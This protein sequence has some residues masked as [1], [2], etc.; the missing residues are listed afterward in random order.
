MNARLNITPTGMTAS[1]GNV[2]T[3]GVIGGV[4]V[5]NNGTDAP[6]YWAG[7][8]TMATITA[9]PAGYTCASLRPFKNYRL[10]STFPRA[11]RTIRIW[12]CGAASRAWI[13]SDE[14]GCDRQDEER[15]RLASNGRRSIASRR[16]TATW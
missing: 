15:R 14:L 9:W 7:T 5:A 4:L 3:G 11:E 13:A 12:C 2:W 16:P 6:F 1:P 8:G 10:P